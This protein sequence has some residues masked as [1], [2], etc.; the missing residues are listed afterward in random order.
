MAKLSKDRAV[1]SQ[2]DSSHL[3]TPLVSRPPPATKPN[4]MLPPKSRPNTV[5]SKRPQPNNAEGSPAVGSN[6]K[7]RRRR[8]RKSSSRGSFSENATTASEDTATT[9][10][11][12]SL[13]KDAQPKGFSVINPALNELRQ[14][15]LRDKE[16]EMFGEYAMSVASESETDAATPVPSRKRKSSPP[17]SVNYRAAQKKPADNQNEA[18]VK[19]IPHPAVKPQVISD[20]ASSIPVVSE[21]PSVEITSQPA[22][23]S[24]K[25]PQKLSSNRHPCPLRAEHNC[26]RTFAD[27][28]NA[29][30][31]ARVHSQ[32][33]TCHIC[34]KT[35]S[36]KDKLKAHLKN[37][38]TPEERAAASNQT[39]AGGQLVANNG[40]NGTSTTSLVANGSKEVEHSPS[41]DESIRSDPSRD[42]P[43]S[44]VELAGEVTDAESETETDS[45]KQET[46]SEKTRDT[47]VSSVA[48]NRA[49]QE[50]S[51]Q[52]ASKQDSPEMEDDASP[53]NS[54]IPDMP[55][56]SSA[57]DR[58]SS[59]TKL[60]NTTSASSKAINGVKRK[61]HTSS[62]TASGSNSDRP[63]KRPRSETT[64]L[65]GNNLSNANQE[66]DTNHSSP[67]EASTRLQ[68]QPS[69][70][71][72]QQ[73]LQSKAGS[74]I[75][76][77]QP[78]ERNIRTSSSCSNSTAHEGGLQDGNTDSESSVQSDA[79]ASEAEDKTRRLSTKKKRLVGNLNNALSRRQSSFDSHVE[80]SE[81][82]S[83][84]TNA[85]TSSRKELT[86]NV[87]HPPPPKKHKF[88]PAA[89]RHPTASA[90]QPEKRRPSPTLTQKGK[91]AADQRS[92]TREAFE[93]EKADRKAAKSNTAKATATSSPKP[94]RKV[95]DKGLSAVSASAANKDSKSIEELQQTLDEENDDTDHEPNTGPN[96]RHKATTVARRTASLSSNKKKSA[97]IRSE[98]SVNNNSVAV[99]SDDSAS[100][101]FSKDRKNTRRPPNS[102]YNFKELAKIGET[103]RMSDEEVHILLS[104]R[105]SFC[106]EH[107]LS[108]HEF[109]EMMEVSCHRGT[110]S[111]RYN[112]INKDEFM[113]QYYDQLPHRNR[114]SL[115][116]FRER[117]FQNVER[118]S[119]TEDDNKELRQLVAQFGPKWVEIGRMMGRTAD[120]VSQRWRHRL[121]YGHEM[122]SG[123]WTDD[124]MQQ[125]ENEVEAFAVSKNTTTDDTD[126]VIPWQAISTKLG[127]GRTAQQCANRWRLST[128]KLVGSTYVKVPHSGRIPKSVTKAP[129]TPSKMEQRLSGHKKTFKSKARIGDRSSSARSQP[130]DR[131]KSAERIVES[132]ESEEDVND[133]DTKDEG[134]ARNED[135]SPEDEANQGSRQSEQSDTDAEEASPANQEDDEQSDDGSDLI[136]VQESSPQPR[137]SSARLS[138][139]SKPRFTAKM[140]PPPSPPN[141]PQQS[142]DKDTQELIVQKSNQSTPVKSRNPFQGVKPQGNQPSLSQVFADT[143]AQS[144]QRTIGGRSVRSRVPDSIAER[145]SP[146]TSIRHRPLSSQSKQ[147]ESD[148]SEEDT[149]EDESEGADDELKSPNS[150]RSAREQSEG[151]KH[152]VDGTTKDNSKQGQ[153]TPSNSESSSDPDN[154]GSSSSDED[155]A[156]PNNT[157]GLSQN[158]FWTAVN[159]FTSRF[160]PGSQRSMTETQKDNMR[161]NKRR[162]LADALNQRHDEDESDEDSDDG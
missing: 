4:S 127:N 7:K 140:M 60:Y 126:L 99:S 1:T 21:S 103:G 27:L 17:L 49:S 85:G 80:R 129:R 3:S 130:N 138:Q 68:N 53:I 64:P 88:L 26:T 32:S 50:E 15:T 144:S 106:E 76:V 133:E 14:Q 28:E 52:D 11:T 58:S 2:Q 94:K 6:Q 9:R 141:R 40:T 61:R 48:T 30:R 91:E 41:K 25:Q 63:S 156:A 86:I 102:E 44:T 117:R 116:R 160:I 20:V 105:D 38:H 162:S 118:G 100:E 131:Y 107:G 154:S 55:N 45:G 36:R 23:V 152:E 73:S 16:P 62:S 119:W 34:Q 59:V 46:H 137:P 5:P 71:V 56:S 66:S 89:T 72:N 96:V 111:W 35:L 74:T 147:A 121:N 39:S 57:T 112:F 153:D 135:S 31:H 115:L 104:W 18:L 161:K 120:D 122:R 75:S 110:T 82:G 157:N 54:T 12:R 159:S 70:A 87:P 114:R 101:A 158:A 95:K 134:D 78:K 149:E 132:D 155:N 22:P 51:S 81:T 150:F 97:T 24:R 65:P 79:E 124:E 145:P 84:H 10:S 93:N 8:G 19:D 83:N 142:A 143:Q 146:D 42:V 123:E 43:V 136:E 151:S 13:G 77:A 67:A 139:K 92:M 47:T 128:T 148:S 125:L 33:L 69:S 90:Q 29:Q 113:R 98:S 108:H 109:N 37:V